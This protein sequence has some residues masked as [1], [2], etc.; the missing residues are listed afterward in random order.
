VANE[1]SSTK[2]YIVERSV[3]GIDYRDIAHVAYQAHTSSVNTYE[4]KDNEN[5]VGTGAVYYRIKV[6]NVSGN[7]QYSKTVSVLMNGLTA[8]LTVFPNP[9]K[10]S[11]TISFVASSGGDISL[12]LS[13]LKGST[14]WQKQT[15]VSAGA[16]S[17]LLDQLANIPNGIYILQWFDG[18]K[19]QQVK[20]VVN[21]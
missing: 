14:I 16:N 2:E 1:N 11:A 12:R 18:L 15:R 6:I 19:P 17:I 9:A 3:N 8:K 4:Y 21:H 13:D 5:I 10:S 20:L 7:G